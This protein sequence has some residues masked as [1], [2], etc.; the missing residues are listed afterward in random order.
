MR[1]K[2]RCWKS[3]TQ[4][5]FLLE[6]GRES[7]S[8]ILTMSFLNLRHGELDPHISDHNSHHFFIA[9]YLLICKKTNACKVLTAMIWNLADIDKRLHT[10]KLC[11]KIWVVL[12]ISGWSRGLIDHPSYASSLFKWLSQVSPLW[13]TDRGWIPAWASEVRTLTSCT[14]R[15]VDVN[16]VS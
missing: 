4:F 10:M 13:M 8:N 16:D 5:F 6:I 15:R 9:T 3:D 1:V 11:L 14:P 2:L 7:L 12:V